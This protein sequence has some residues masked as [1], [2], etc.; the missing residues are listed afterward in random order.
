MNILMKSLGHTE[1]GDCKIITLEITQKVVMAIEPKK[2]FA[3]SITDAEKNIFF[4]NH[5]LNPILLVFGQ[6]LLPI[7]IVYN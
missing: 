6:V 4:A 5:I 2:L 7:N 1:S 3:H